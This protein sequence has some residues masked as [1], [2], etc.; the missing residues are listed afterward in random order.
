M[1]DID[2]VRD[3]LPP[4][5]LVLG[6]D[7]AKIQQ[8]IDDAGSVSKAVLAFWRWRAGQTVNMIDVSESGSSRSLSTIHKHA[9]DMVK[10]WTDEVKREQDRA[11]QLLNEFS[12]RRRA[13]LHVAKRV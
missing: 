5:A 8:V 3:Q 9:M 12:G 7:D 11:D 6:W 2:M 4:N 13:R 10:Y 1:A